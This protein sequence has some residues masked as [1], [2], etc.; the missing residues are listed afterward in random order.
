[1]SGEENSERATLSEVQASMPENGNPLLEIDHLSKEFAARDSIF[2]RSRRIV[3]A[4]RDV[5]FK[6]YPETTF[7][8]VGE[9]GCGK[10][11]LLRCILQMIRPTAGR[12]AFDGVDLVKL[13]SSELRIKRRDL[14]MVFQNPFNSLNPRLSVLAIVSEPLRTHTK[15]SHGEIHDRILDLLEQVGLER[16][17]L[18]RY[19]HE[20]SG[21]QLQRIAIARALSSNP[22]FICL[23]EPT[24]ALD[25]SVQAQI[26]TL[27]QNLQREMKLT[28]LFV[29]HNL[30][31]VNHI[32]DQIAVMYLGRIVEIA[33][34]K[35]LFENPLHPYT[36]ALVSATPS[37]KADSRKDRIRIEGEIPDASNPPSGCYFHPRC[38]YA[39]DLCFVKYPQMTKIDKMH[40]VAC[41]LI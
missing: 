26:I 7:G 13:P 25:V 5:S 38:P 32:S 24:S 39:K 21:G 8:I 37:L 29:S 31:L 34:V 20:F 4:L 28:Y 41:H 36:K 19:P 2:R 15:M 6:I 35:S 23:D 1:L 40:F 11:T 10:T 22:K 27:L 12:V 30:S 3:H 33:D 17:H 9:S 18:Y 16:D 14:Q